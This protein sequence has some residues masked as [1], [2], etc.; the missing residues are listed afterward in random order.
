MQ[1][2]ARLG[3]FAGAVV[4]AVR[5]VKGG[6][7]WWKDWPGTRA[8]PDQCA[9]ARRRPARA[10]PGYVRGLA[11]YLEH[12]DAARGGG[13]YSRGGCLA[14]LAYGDALDIIR[15]LR[16]K[17]HKNGSES[18][19]ADCARKWFGNERKAR[20]CGC[21]DK[22]L[23]PLCG[24][25]EAEL[26]AKEACD[27]LYGEFLEAAKPRIGKLESMGTAWEV[28]LH[29]WLSS[30]LELVLLDDPVRW[31]KE[32]NRIAGEM[33]ETIELAY[34]GGRI[35]G[36]QSLQ[37]YGESN[38][39]EPHFHGHHVLA[40]IVLEGELSEMLEGEVKIDDKGQA[41][42][43][44][45][46]QR[47]AGDFKVKPLPRF[48]A[49]DVLATLRLDWGRRQL[50]LA[51]RLNVKLPLVAGFVSSVALRRLL[52]SPGKK[53]KLKPVLVGDVHLSYFGCGKGYEKAVQRAKGYLGYQARWP[54]QDLISGLKGDGSR[55]TWTGAMG[56][57]PKPEVFGAGACFTGRYAK[58]GRPIYERQLSPVDVAKAIGRLDGVPKAWP[59]LRWRGYLSTFNVSQVMG[60]LGWT[61]A[62]FDSEE[63]VQR[64]EIEGLQVQLDKVGQEMTELE[65]MGREIPEELRIRSEEIEEEIQV[66][67]TRVV[68]EEDES[69]TPAQLLLPV[70]KFEGGLVFCTEAG[71][72][73]GVPWENLRLGPVGFGGEVL[74]KGRTKY[75]RSRDGPVTGQHVNPAGGG[76]GL[77]ESHCWQCRASV[78]TGQNQ[79]CMSCGW[80]KCG[81]CGCCSHYCKG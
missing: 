9:P 79:K 17:G 7:A 24:S 8:N 71:L 23:C 32:T 28:P 27:F 75:W 60:G 41:W 35:G 57:K 33:W 46:E 1:C 48:V 2:F 5:E 4:V 65:E 40:P 47:V 10:Y 72:E 16:H 6:F 30:W 58:G 13:G 77:R 49:G 12:T 34:P 39:A 19:V 69:V 44:D 54:G 53:L 81:R 29:K 18:S 64:R 3:Q 37:L 25:K 51:K 67:L 38:P 45:D 26:I 31:R 76:F 59:R 63:D 70:G 56:S 50:N 36:Y 74:Q 14:E 55:Y 15:N 22:R 43:T 62:N 68:P 11:H 66:I 52:N 73:V 42:I 78:E 20:P 80:L 21:D 61:Q